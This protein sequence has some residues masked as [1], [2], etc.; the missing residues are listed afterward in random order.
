MEIGLLIILLIVVALPLSVRKIEE[1][2]EIFL[3]VMGI[4]A[5]LVSG[6]IDF[7][8]M[9]K[10]LAEFGRI[11]SNIN[12]YLITG[13]VFGLGILFMLF[14]K[15]IDYVAGTLLE[16][17]PL[18]LAVA[19]I[20]LFLGLLS[21]LITAII[22]SLLLAEIISMLP[23]HRKEAFR[24]N[25]IA[26]YSIGLGAVLTP[27]GEPLSTIVVSKLNAGF[28]YLFDLLWIYIIPIVILLAAFGALTV[29]SWQAD[30]DV[31]IEQIDPE[32]KTFKGTVLRSVKI[33][34]FII[35]LEL[36]G[37]GFQPVID[38]Y[39][40][41]LNDYILYVLNLL[42]AILD[43]ATLAA[44]EVSPLMNAIQLKTILMSL[45]I[46]G[47]MLITGNIPNIVTASRLKIRSRDWAKMALPIGAVL[48][49][50]YLIY[51]LIF[52]NI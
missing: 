11:F 26:C 21:S 16:K 50:G 17:I 14:E 9:G 35:A 37:A 6:V 15:K 38:A 31:A 4:A 18:R 25:I 23:L 40:I 48:F 44:A 49:F 13:I 22:A 36:L 32:K 28:F 1:N 20:I 41:K 8:D 43:N 30:R 5:A 2:L 7:G 19:L 34:A 46:S 10:T 29:K 39:V 12:L 27:V 52:H 42:S 3:L 24:I 33:F 51:S 45:L 47:G